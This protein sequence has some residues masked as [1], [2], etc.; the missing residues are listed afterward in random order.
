MKKIFNNP[1]FTFVLGAIIFGTTGVIAATLMATNVSYSNTNSGINANNVQDAIDIL[2]DKANNPIIPSNYKDLSTETTAIS[3][4]IVSGKT[5]YN[6]DGTLLT[7]SMSDYNGV[8]SI[9]PAT[10]AQ[11]IQTAG[12]YNSNNITINAIPSNYKDVSLSTI[13]N[14]NDIVAGKTAYLNN[15]S[16]VTGTYN[17]STKGVEWD[18]G[19]TTM[20]N[21]AFSF[22]T[23]FT[24]AK[25]IIYIN[26]TNHGGGEA[27]FFVNGTSGKY[28]ESGY[29]AYG[30]NSSQSA[31]VWS[32]ESNLCDNGV[33]CYSNSTWS[34]INYSDI[35]GRV[36]WYIF[37]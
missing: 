28:Y 37:K 12:K 34:V 32:Q 17:P 27:V 26:M 2:Y 13:S 11:T 7:G 3:S 30:S 19:T 25:T 36:D 10:N 9:T 15:G 20:T 16:L 22:P 29:T 18:S 31:W 23:S 24:P 14:T 6:S 4:E 33:M 1:I 5:A 8:T 21:G 35:S